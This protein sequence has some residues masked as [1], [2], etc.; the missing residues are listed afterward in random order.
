MRT[1]NCHAFGNVE[2]FS[3]FVKWGSHGV[4]KM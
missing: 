1:G 3:D 4:A 2:D